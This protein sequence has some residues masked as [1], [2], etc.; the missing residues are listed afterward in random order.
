MR[1]CV[2]IGVLVIGIERL[3]AEL[4]SAEQTLSVAWQQHFGKLGLVFQQ[5][6]GNGVSAVGGTEAMPQIA[7]APLWL[8]HSNTRFAIFWAWHI[9]LLERRFKKSLAG[10][11]LKKPASYGGFFVAC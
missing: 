9:V 11:W 6:A 10:D 1:E 5:Y 8:L 7:Q 3:S 4:E 2:E